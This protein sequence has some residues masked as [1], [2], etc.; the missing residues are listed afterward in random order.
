MLFN[1][2]DK[3]Y[4]K[5]V[6]LEAKFLENI[7]KPILEDIGKPDLAKSILVTKQKVIQ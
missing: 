5:Y 7:H 6:E 3:K 2:K 4:V 1:K